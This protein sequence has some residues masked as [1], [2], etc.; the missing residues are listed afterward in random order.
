[1]L[2]LPNK[3]INCNYYLFIEAVFLSASVKKNRC[4]Q[5]LDTGSFLLINRAYFRKI[6]FDNDFSCAAVRITD[7]VQT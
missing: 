1:M 3:H 7:N 2:V 5:K 6:S 4:P